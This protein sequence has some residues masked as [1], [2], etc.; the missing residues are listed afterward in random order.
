MKDRPAIMGDGVVLEVEDDDVHYADR[1]AAG[2]MSW[3]RDNP[4]WQTR[5]EARNE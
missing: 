2:M 1:H 5:I 4:E 3:E